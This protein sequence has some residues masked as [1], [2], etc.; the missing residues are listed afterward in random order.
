MFDHINEYLRATLASDAQ[1]QRQRCQRICTAAALS[2]DH[3]TAPGRAAG[4][5][6]RLPGRR[7]HRLPLPPLLVQPLVEN[8]IRRAS[9]EH[10]RRRGHAVG[11]AVSERLQDS[12]A[13]S[14][15]GIGTQAN[16][17]VGNVGLNNIRQRLRALFGDAATCS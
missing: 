11:Q 3:A 7:W 15:S 5:S 8:A 4:V 2:G 9:T 1:R 16:G 10:Q 6:D 14:G 12:V 13:D 17:D